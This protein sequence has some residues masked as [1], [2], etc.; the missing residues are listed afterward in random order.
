LKAFYLVIRCPIKNLSDSEEIRIWRGQRETIAPSYLS[1][2]ELER[3]TF[4]GHENILGTH[5]NTLE[6]TK[7]ECMSKRADCIIGVGAEK[8]CA[9]LCSETKRWLWDGKWLGLE[10]RCAHVSFS[11]VGRG[12]STL[13]LKDPN[14]IVFRKSDFTS[15]RTLALR[16]SHAACDIPRK[17][18]S[19]LQDPN[20]SAELIVR[21][22][23]GKLDDQIIWNLP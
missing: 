9:D 22:L 23:P 7:D 10:I 18:I 13:D 5:K 2:K 12:S 3:I 21:S 19:F 11:F 14:E 8:G 4:H 6:I 16:C 20:T 1:S 15:S 17:M